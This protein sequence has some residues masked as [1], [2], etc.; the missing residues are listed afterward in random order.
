M[1]NLI[2]K[3]YIERLHQG[4]IHM[5]IL[6]VSTSD[7]RQATFWQER[8]S[9]TCNSSLIITVVEDWKG[10]AG[11]GLGTLYAFSKAQRQAKDLHQLD[12]LQAMQEG[13]SI[14]IYHTAGKGMRLMPLTLSESNNKS[15]VKLPGLIEKNGATEAITL[16]EAVIKQTSLFASSRKGRLSVFWGDQIFIPSQ[17]ID[18][19][20]QHHVDILIKKVGLPTKEMWEKEGLHNYG[21]VAIDQ[22]QNGQLLEK[23]NFETFVGLVKDNKISTKG[24][25][26]ISLGSFSLSWEMTK[27]LLEEFAQEL[28]SKK[29]KLDTD[30]AF[31]MALTLDEEIYLKG[32]EKHAS[33]EFSKKHFQRMKSFEDKLGTQY[34]QKQKFGYVDIGKESL[35][36]DY[37]TTQSYYQNALKLLAQNDESNLMKMFFNL[38]DKYDPFTQS[39][40]VGSKI[41][42]GSVNHSIVIGCEGKSLDISNSLMINTSFEELKGENCLIY[43]AKMRNMD[44]LSRGQIRSDILMMSKKHVKMYTDLHRDGKVDWQIQ[45]PKNEFSYET[46]HEIIQ[47]ESV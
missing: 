18:Y 15:A 42:K 21:L 27:S 28:Q 36:W 13:A 8:L 34:P 11:N 19:T 24:G 22:E 4:K 6:I 9:S 35:W 29:G 39:I 41:E 40:V 5:D 37:G 23:T 26:G 2:Q 17:S 3:D 32:M 30:T 14:A 44:D 10:G 20:P 7:T 25:V 46:L 31:W 1:I 47:G 43:N 45:L 38:E 16:L 33:Q 12:L